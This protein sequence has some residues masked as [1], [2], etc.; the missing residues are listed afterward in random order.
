MSL[1]G[2]S[3]SYA[4]RLCDVSMRLF[5]FRAYDSPEGRAVL[6]PAFSMT[7]DFL[8]V[9]V[10][11]LLRASAAGVSS[12]QRSIHK[13]NQRTMPPFPLC[14][15]NCVSIP[16][17][18]S[19]SP[20][21]PPSQSQPFPLSPTRQLSALSTKLVTR[22]AAYPQRLV[23]HSPLTNPSVLVRFDI[24]GAQIACHLTPVR[25]PIAVTFACGL[26]YI[27]HS[28]PKTPVSLAPLPPADKCIPDPG[29]IPAPSVPTRVILM[30]PNLP[31]WPVERHPWLVRRVESI[32][33]D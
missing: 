26:S 17:S 12:S 19:H 10:R 5:S 6:T 22:L 16:T 32:E 14:F 23:L 2:T 20:L 9:Y 1:L 33:V 25:D 8:A 29:L 13:A 15:T 30:G 7:T 28:Q 21:P 31:R 24:D 3:E 11:P 27:L 18:L 4:S